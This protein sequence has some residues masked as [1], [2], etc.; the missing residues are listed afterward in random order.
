MRHQSVI[1]IFLVALTWIAILPV[2]AG[3]QLLDPEIS[4]GIGAIEGIRDGTL[5]RMR[6]WHKG[7]EEQFGT[8]PPAPIKAL[9]MENAKRLDILENE[10]KKLAEELLDKEKMV[11]LKENSSKVRALVY[12]AAYAGESLFPLFRSGCTIRMSI[13]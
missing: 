12:L 10:T 13:E 2:S 3:G 1:A 4:K 5:K 11:L 8:N 6:E 7:C 9:L